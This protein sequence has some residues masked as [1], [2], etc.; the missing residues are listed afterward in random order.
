M[1]VEAT[2]DDYKNINEN[3]KSFAEA[4]GMAEDSIF[5]L[6]TCEAALKAINESSTF[7]DLLDANN[8]ASYT[9]RKDALSLQGVTIEGFATFVTLEIRLMNIEKFVRESFSHVVLRERQDGRVRYEIS[10]K[11]VKISDIF[12]SIEMKKCQ[13]CLADY[14]VSQTSLEQVFNMHAAEAEQQ[15]IGRIEHSTVRE[16]NTADSTRSIVSIEDQF[17]S[18]ETDRHLHSH[19][20]HNR[21]HDQPYD[22]NSL[23][24]YDESLPFDAH[25]IP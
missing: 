25:C 9:I 3:L 19:I 6:A 2:D 16:C 15:K 4:R 7:P 22:E 5:D 1:I 20:R 13:L 24:L 11:N 18:Q 12:S 17:L 8:S 21:E 23:N 14:S 10:D